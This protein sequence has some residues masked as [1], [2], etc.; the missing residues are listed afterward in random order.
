M[1]ETRLG[2]ILE[3]A[4]RLTGRD[5]SV[6]PIPEDF[7]VL[8][9][10]SLNSAIRD[11]SSEHLPMMQRV[12]FRRYRPNFDKGM[13]WTKGQECWHNGR[14]WRLETEF[15]LHDPGDG[16][17]WRPLGPCEVM[18]FIAWDQPWEIM[19]IDRAGLDANYFAFAEDPRYCPAATPVRIVGITDIGIELE[20]GKAPDGVYVKF[21]PEYPKVSFVAWDGEKSYEPGDVVY[22]PATKDVYECLSASSGEDPSSSDKWTPVRISDEFEMYLTRY[23]FGDIATEAQGKYQ[24]KAEAATEL[25]KIRSRYTTNISAPVRRGSFRNR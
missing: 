9:A 22:S 20:A 18:S 8:A 13:A 12:E 24:T 15:S 23:V 16:V 6:N 14:Y 3:N 19:T 2:E 4:V 21:V 1:H 10:M 17:C 5:V 7:K 25:E 11:L